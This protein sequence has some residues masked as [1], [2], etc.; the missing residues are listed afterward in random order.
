V[1]SSFFHAVVYAP[2]YNALA[3]FI[4]WIPGG[5]IGIAI[6]LITVLIKLI[7]FP[8]AVKASHTQ[9]AMRR[10][11]PE[12]KA[13]RDA[14]KDKPQD[15]ALKTMALYKDNKINPFASFAVLI[16][17]LPVILGLYWV[18]WAESKGGTFD[19]SILYPFVHAP[20]TVSFTFL[21]I[22]PI[23]SSSVIL[24]V[25]VA[26]TQYYQTR[27]MMPNAPEK[28]GKGFQD[29]LAT[30]MHLQMRYVFPV[31]LGVISYV[32]TAA[33]A[34]YFLTSNFFGI[35]QELTAKARHDKEYGS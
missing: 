32:A 5:D 21:G 35:M 7:L 23:A 10:L 9:R 16:I 17:Q 29:D 18:I 25:L 27:L 33:V 3:L 26:G 28:T 4:G 2:I 11:E 1:I 24:A 12:L 15:L 6:I 14:Y 20:T 31:V 34:L 8:L 13:L 22:L 19:P 30:S